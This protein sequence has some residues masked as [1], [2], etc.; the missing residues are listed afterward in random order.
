MVVVAWWWVDGLWSSECRL[1]LLV[2]SGLLWC[3]GSAVDVTALFMILFT[4]LVDAHCR[5]HSGPFQGF[6]QHRLDA[7]LALLRSLRPP[8]SSYAQGVFRV[9]AYLCPGFRVLS[10]W[11]S[12]VTNAL[13]GTS[14]E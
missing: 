4:S 1:P 14:L 6:E 2:K 5:S 8:S 3:V 11:R 13:S 10:R 9:I 12:G 7:S